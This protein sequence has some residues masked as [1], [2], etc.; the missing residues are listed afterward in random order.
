MLI[1]DYMIFEFYADV[2]IPGKYRQLKGIEPFIVITIKTDKI[3]SSQK[4]DPEME[5]NQE[6]KYQ[7]KVYFR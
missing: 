6:Y 2:L 1:P 7:E 3:F 5:S 4:E